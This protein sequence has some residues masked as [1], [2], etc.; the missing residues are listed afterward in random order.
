MRERLKKLIRSGVSQSE[1]RCKDYGCYDYGDVADYLLD[2]GVI[3]PP[4][5]VGDNIY[6]LFGNKVDEEVL[7]SCEYSRASGFSYM[8]SNGKFP[9]LFKEEDIGK[10]VYLSREEAEKALKRKE[11]EGK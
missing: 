3:V 7:V 10:T 6:T 11:V 1:Q 9:T 4:C 2:N 8:S 5:K